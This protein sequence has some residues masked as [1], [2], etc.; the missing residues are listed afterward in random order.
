M[1]GKKKPSPKNWVFRFFLLV[2]LAAFIPTTTVALLALNASTQA[3]RREAETELSVSN[4]STRQQLIRWTKT[5]RNDLVFASKS[6]EDLVRKFTEFFQ[7]PKNSK[8]SE[9]VKSEIVGNEIKRFLDHHNNFFELFVIDPKTGEVVISSAPEEE[10]KLKTDRPYFINGKEATYTQNVYFSLTLQQQAMTIATPVFNIGGD[11]IAVLAG[12]VSL[13]TLNDILRLPE[14]LGETAH[15]YTIN[16]SK[17]ITAGLQEAEQIAAKKYYFRPLNT[18]P[19]LEGLKGKS[20]I[21]TYNTY[22]NTKVV[23]SYL[24]IPELG[25]VVV[26][27][28]EEEEILQPTQSL[29]SIVLVVALPSFLVVALVAIQLTRVMISSTQRYRVGL[30]Q[31]NLQ[32]LE[33]QK[34]LEKQNVTLVRNTLSMTEYR[35]KLEDKNAELAR[36]LEQTKKLSSVVASEKKQTETLLQSLTDGAFAVDQNNKI[37]LF[38]KAAENITGI[39]GKS[40]MNKNVDQVLRFYKKTRQAEAVH[41]KSEQIS[42]SQYTD[43]SAKIKKELK[44][45]GLLIDNEKDVTFVSLNSAPVAFGEPDSKGWIITF[46]D[47]T[48]EREF[49]EMKLDFVSMAAHELRTPLTSIRG[50]ADVLIREIGDK[51]DSGHKEDLKRLS[52]SSINLSNLIDNFLNVT[53]IERDTFK[54]QLVPTDLATLV[55]E[56]IRDFKR[57]VESKKQTLKFVKPKRK[58]PQVL[59]DGSRIAEVITNLISNA[60]TYTGEGGKIKVS[61]NSRKKSGEREGDFVAV[62]IKD[63]GQGIPRRALPKLFTKFFRVSGVLEQ[64]SKGTGLGLFI[65]KSIIKKHKG[66]IWA[67]SQLGKGSTFTFTIPVATEKNLADYKKTKS[68]LPKGNIGGII[69]NKEKYK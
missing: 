67:E 41:K 19:V 27:E 51:L 4:N 64:G 38:N 20:G 28:I 40:V 29:K 33:T 50:Y 3:L 2:L 24:P 48:K 18:L 39:S 32:L 1:S 34:S 9:E 61:I 26:T 53:R 25:V 42:I 17:F 60:I 65:S 54:I 68:K 66:Y 47:I 35:N 21:A 7:L 43:Q 12:R 49:E 69:F 5:N 6:S 57:Q 14:G 8:E 44:E 36:A 56:V 58:M 16:S 22:N 37:I 11:L 55:Q 45:E 10:G 15:S 13:D 52:I 23:G 46:H 31:T 62:S 30:E 59:A 63:T